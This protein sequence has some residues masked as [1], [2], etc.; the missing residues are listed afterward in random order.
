M[1]ELS[2]TVQV[3]NPAEALRN[4][5]GTFKVTS[6]DGHVFQVTC[7][8]GSNMRIR[9]IAGDGNVSPAER[10]RWEIEKLAQPIV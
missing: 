3:E 10:K 8:R 7:R 6:P 2:G 9:E 5:S 1:I 4:Q